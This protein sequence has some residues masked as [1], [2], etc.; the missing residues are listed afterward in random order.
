MSWATCY[1]GSN[2]I[3][4]SAPALMSDERL[5]TSY[6]SACDINKSLRENQGITSNYT[7]RQYLQNNALN[8]IDNNTKSSMSCSNRICLNSNDDHNNKYLFSSCADR[9][10]PFGYETSDLKNM[11]LSSKSLNSELSGPIITQE[12]LLI[13][14]SA[15]N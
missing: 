6:T 10:Q 14:R 15:K 8:I 12:Q 7:Y 3:H 2:N 5:F 1:S 13:N 4:H 11:Y 9:S